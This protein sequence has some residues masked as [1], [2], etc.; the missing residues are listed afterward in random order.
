MSATVSPIRPGLQWQ[1]NVH[2]MHALPP[3]VRLLD[4]QDWRD[5]TAPARS[6]M[7]NFDVAGSAD[8]LVEA[9]IV[10]HS[11][12][13][14]IP[15]CGKKVIREDEPINRMMYL[16]RRRTDYRVDL[17]LYGQ[18]NPELPKYV[19]MFSL[20]RKVK[21]RDPR[22]SLPSCA[23]EIAALWL[24][25]GTVENRDN[26]ERFMRQLLKGARPS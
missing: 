15:K 22:A 14:S 9:G 23:V 10:T 7:L 12:L 11:E 25:L 13:A 8:A 20:D 4:L 6:I 19:A 26:A 1:P 21:S 24:S 5:S 3:G 16:Y 2:Y 18:D 17:C